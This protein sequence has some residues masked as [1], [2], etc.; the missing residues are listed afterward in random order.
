[1]GFMVE[2]QVDP[3]AS[4][5]IADWLGSVGELLTLPE[6]MTA[7]TYVVAEG[8]LINPFE[9]GITS[10]LAIGPGLGIG[11]LYVEW[12]YQLA[13]GGG[14]GSPGELG[15]LATSGPIL[16]FGLAPFEF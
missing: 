3:N 13:E 8:K 2:M 10:V 1:M 6:T 11:P 7:R 16:R 14:V 4:V 5:P 15:N 9:G 12:V